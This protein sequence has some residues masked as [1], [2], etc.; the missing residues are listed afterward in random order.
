M[1]GILEAN[2]FYNNV[3]IDNKFIKFTYLNYATLYCIPTLA[4]FIL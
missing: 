1:I 4:T 2:Y 3:D